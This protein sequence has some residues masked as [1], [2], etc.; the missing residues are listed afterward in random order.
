MCSSDL[1]KTLQSKAPIYDV[2]DSASQKVTG[3]NQIWT[4]G[5]DVHD[6]IPFPSEKE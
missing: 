3:F 6:L 1:L 5:A 4:T 2:S